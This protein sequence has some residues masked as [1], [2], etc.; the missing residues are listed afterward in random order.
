MYHLRVFQTW[1]PGSLCVL[2]V[3]PCSLRFASV[4]F[5]P[6]L[7]TTERTRSMPEP[8]SY[9]NHTRWFPPFHFF[10]APVLVLNLIFAIALTIH[11]WHWHRVLFLWYIV[12][13]S[14]ERRVGEECR[15]RW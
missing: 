4:F 7:S 2:S 10:A 1:D 15:S 9:K 12:L 8:Q 13:R 5:N 3:P 6:S 11:H 14:E